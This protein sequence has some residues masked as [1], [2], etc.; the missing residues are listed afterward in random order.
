MSASGAG[1]EQHRNQQSRDEPHRD[2]RLRDAYARLTRT[3]HD[4]ASCPAPDVLLA[5][6]ER[7]GSEARRLATMRH[8]ASCTSC[9][10]DID[11]LRT[12]AQA[13]RATEPGHGARLATW[14]RP[15]A[16]AATLLIAA[17]I[18]AYVRARH[19]TP[20]PVM[21][22]G[23]ALAFHPARRVGA[24]GALL[25]WRP[26]L[27]A[28]RYDLTLIDGDGREL[29]RHALP[30]TA[31]IVADSLVRDA[32]DVVVSV[33]AVLRDGSSLGPSSAPLAS[34]TR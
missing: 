29:L 28:M 21:R 15:I 8:V 18:G 12:A 31:S 7:H 26:A 25:S 11:L 2:Q 14:S 5:V 10:R 30:D 24:G 16:L 9:R 34:L 33:S 23:E 1:D 32:R 19:L 6:V 17:G 4:R 3:P 22:G 13:A 27:G 20:A